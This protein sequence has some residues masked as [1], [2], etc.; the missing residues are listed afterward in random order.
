MMK[1]LKLG[2]ICAGNLGAAL[3]EAVLKKRLYK[4]SEI[5]T[6]RRGGNNKG[7]V[8]KAETILLCVKPSDM[9]NLLEEIRNEI[10]KHH[11]IITVAAGLDTKFYSQFLPKG[12]R[13][14]RA[15][16]NRPAI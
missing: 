11:L 9:R 6:T 15:M 7:L 16:P 10:K 5:E 13:L 8:R 3:K 12:T 14:I 2:L 4:P 1:N